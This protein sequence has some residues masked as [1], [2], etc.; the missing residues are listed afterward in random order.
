MGFL[1]QEYWSGLLCPSPGDLPNP[2]TEPTSPVWQVDSLPLSHLG[3]PA[4]NRRWLHVIR[5]HSL[6]PH[7][8]C[9]NWAY[10][11]PGTARLSECGLCSH[12][13]GPLWLK[14]K[15]LNQHFRTFLGWPQPTS[16]DSCSPFLSELVTLSR[17]MS[18]KYPLLC[19]LNRNI[20]FIGMLIYTHSNF[21]TNSGKL[22]V[23]M[24][25]LSSPTH[26]P[27]N[28]IP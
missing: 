11:V 15:L 20:F 19:F 17:L 16:T 8:V 21:N 28:P 4:S 9:V 25:P 6:I 7:Q 12:F 13:H 1:R 23:K 5:L 26:Y 3:S 18:L 10:Y 27:P 24:C 14:S 22:K 2:G